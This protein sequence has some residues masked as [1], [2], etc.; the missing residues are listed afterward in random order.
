MRRILA[1]AAATAI[2]AIPAAGGFPSAVYGQSGTAPASGASG[3]TTTPSGSAPQD[4]LAEAARKARE[5][6]KDAPKPTKVFDNDNLPASGGISTVGEAPAPADAG[7]GAADATAAPAGKTGNGEKEWKQRFA[8]LRAKV[9]RDQADLDVMQRELGVDWVQF[10][11]GDPTKAM[12]QELTRDNI[13][14]KTSDIDAKRLQVAA[15]KQA[16]DDATDE[17]RKSGG[18]VGWSR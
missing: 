5:S 4:S 17:L 1:W 8:D 15:D 14:K 10:N 3:T 6:K 16:I 12:Q 11:S 7:A 2:L 13:N 18:D 9:A